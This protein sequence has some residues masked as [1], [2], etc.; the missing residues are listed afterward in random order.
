[1]KRSSALA[2][3]LA[4]G[5]GFVALSE[6]ALRN[7]SRTSICT[8]IRRPKVFSVVGQRNQTIR[9]ALVKCSLPR[10]SLY[11]PPRFGISLYF[12]YQNYRLRIACRQESD[13]RNGGRVRTGRTGSGRARVHCNVC[14]ACVGAVLVTNTTS[15]AQSLDRGSVGLMPWETSTP[16]AFVLCTSVVQDKA[17]TFN[18]EC[19]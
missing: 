4:I 15:P 11:S 7:A 6:L 19:M 18:I 8:C 5:I 1:M 9:E 2:G 13:K 10:S 12:V 16:S 17:L 3:R 14:M